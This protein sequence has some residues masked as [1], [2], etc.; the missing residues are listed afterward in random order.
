MFHVIF[1]IWFGL[2]NSLQSTLEKVSQLRYILSAVM[3]TG[4]NCKNCGLFNYEKNEQCI[5]CFQPNP[6]PRQISISDR[7]RIITEYWFRII[8]ACA[9]SIQDIISIILE[10]AKN[11]EFDASVSDIGCKIEN[12]TRLSTMYRTGGYCSA[13]GAIIATPGNIYY[14]KIKIVESATADINI[15]VIEANEYGSKSWWGRES[16]IHI[17]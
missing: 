10:F 14:W 2:K 6:N 9:I 13:F 15:G 4:W 7:H 3:S 12:G 8:M 17:G 1:S 11:D 5:A 16:D